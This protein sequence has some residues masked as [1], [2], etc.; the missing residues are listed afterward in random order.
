MPWRSKAYSWVFVF[1]TGPLVLRPVQ[2]TTA[3]ENIKYIRETTHR[4]SRNKNYDAV[5]SDLIIII[6]F[7]LD[8]LVSFVPKIEK[9]DFLAFSMGFPN[10]YFFLNEPRTYACEQN[11]RIS[12]SVGPFCIILPLLFHSLWLGLVGTVCYHTYLPVCHRLQ[13]NL[14]PVERIFLLIKC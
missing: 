12:Q 4:I 1:H 14:I 2:L 9:L 5:V 3:I 11:N 7:I 6:R 13:I 8:D 10:F